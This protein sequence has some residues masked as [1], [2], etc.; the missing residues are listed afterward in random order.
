MRSTRVSRVMPALA[1]RTSTG[2]Q[3]SST[4]AK[5]ASTCAGIGHIAGQ[6]EELPGPL[7]DVL[8]DH[9]GPGGDR[10]PVAP[11]QEPPGTGQADP[12]GPTGDTTT[13]PTGSPSGPAVRSPWWQPVLRSSAFFPEGPIAAGPAPATGH[14]APRG[15]DPGHWL[16]LDH[17]LAPHGQPADQDTGEGRAD[18]GQAHRAHPVTHGQH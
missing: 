9:P 5:A 1:T 18:V 3:A 15:A 16:A 8:L 2:A 6:G 7:G 12:P 4:A 17:P 14:D 11:G 10:H 13:R